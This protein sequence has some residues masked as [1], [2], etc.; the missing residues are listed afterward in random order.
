MDQSVSG[1]A[2]SGAGLSLPPRAA[3][4]VVDPDRRHFRL[5][6]LLAYY[7]RDFVQF[8]YLV[9]LGRDPDTAGLDSRLQ[10]LQQGRRSRVGLL[11]RMRHSAEG[12]VRGARIKGL[13]RAFAVECAGA[14]PVLGY[15]VRGLRALISLP[16]LHRELEDLRANLV[17]QRNDMDDRLARVVEYQNRVSRDA[18]YANISPE[19]TDGQ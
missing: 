19:S 4:P 16:R 5:S 14:V 6:E 8:A 10:A 15:L 17:M 13:Y 12:K 3:F 11:M 9:V 7:D 2:G 1:L 18:R